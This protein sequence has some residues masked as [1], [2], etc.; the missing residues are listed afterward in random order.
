MRGGK[1]GRALRVFR[2]RCAP[3]TSEV[4]LCR[5]DAT[6]G[7]DKVK[8]M[9]RAAMPRSVTAVIPN[10]YAPSSPAWDSAVELPQWGFRSRASAV[11]LPQWGFRS[12]ASGGSLAWGAPEGCGRPKGGRTGLVRQQG[13]RNAEGW[14]SQVDRES[15]RN[16]ETPDSRTLRLRMGRTGFGANGPPALLQ[17]PDRAQLDIDVL[18]GGLPLPRLAGQLLAQILRLLLRLRSRPS[19]GLSAPLPPSPACSKVPLSLSLTTDVFACVD[20]HSRR[21]PTCQR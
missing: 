7:S 18:Q 6:G 13:A 2:M 4:T 20:P 11:G 9:S 12:D 8:R 14:D 5:G 21:V 1:W 15:P 3:R 19:P 17:R 16:C 10:A